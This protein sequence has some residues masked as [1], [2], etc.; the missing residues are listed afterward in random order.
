MNRIRGGFRNEVTCKPELIFSMERNWDPTVK[1]FFVRILNSIALGLFWM[2]A[3]V[4]AGIYYELGY[5]NGK[6]VIYIILF[7]IVML[8]SLFLLIRYLVR[9]WKKG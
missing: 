4:I 7:Y 5:T 3:C 6:P 2:L 8:G 9:L 1:K